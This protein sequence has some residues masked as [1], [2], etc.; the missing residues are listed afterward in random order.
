MKTWNFSG[1]LFLKVKPRYH[2]DLLHTEWI[3]SF[4]CINCMHFIWFYWSQCEILFSEVQRSKHEPRHLNH[5]FSKTAYSRPCRTWNLSLLLGWMWAHV[6]SY[7]PGT[8]HGYASCDITISTKNG[9]M[10]KR[11]RTILRQCIKT[12]AFT[13]SWVGAQRVKQPLNAAMCYYRRDS[14]VAGWRYD[15][16]RSAAALSQ[17]LHHVQP[18]ASAGARYQHGLTLP[19]GRTHVRL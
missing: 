9:R 11:N 19:P 4:E 18:D 1:H 10:H 15:S 7:M 5:H 13:V 17:L 8:Q 12:A 3:V 14:R 16:V 6:V 2:A